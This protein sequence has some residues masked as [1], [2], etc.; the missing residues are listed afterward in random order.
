MNNWQIWGK[1]IFNDYVKIEI[2]AETILLSL[3][4]ILNQQRKIMVGNIVDPCGITD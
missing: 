2:P 4:C 1:H 3:Y